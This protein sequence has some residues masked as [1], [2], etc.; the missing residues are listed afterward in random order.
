MRLA[1][2]AYNLRTG[3][4][5]SVGRNLTPALCRAAPQWRFRVIVPQG[6]GYE[7]D[8]GSLPNVELIPC[9][10]S[11][12][13]LGRWV[14]DN[15]TAARLVRE[16]RPDV[17]LGLG[18]RGLSQPP[19][20][21]TIL[22]HDAHLFYPVQHYSSEM[23]RRKVLKAYQR[24][25][26]A[27]HLAVTDLLLCQTLTAEARLRRQFRY[28]GAAAIC[29]NAVPTV[30]EQDGDPPDEPSAL[31]SAKG[32]VRLFC[33][34]RYYAHKN[35]EVLLEC[36]RRYPRELASVIVVA[37]I[38]A[39]HH[40]GAPRFLHDIRQYG[41]ADAIVNVGPVPQA[42]L[43]A[44]YR[45][46]DGLMLP[47][48]L[49]SFSGTYLEAMHFGVPIL[50]SN[51][52]FAREVCGDAAL[53]FD[54]WSPASVKDAMVRFADDAQ[55]RADLASAGR[56]RLAQFGRTWDEIGAELAQRLEELARMPRSS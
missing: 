45:H 34:T 6:Y 7:E 14:F 43:G 53:Y 21:Q 46:C 2:L 5:L 40:P 39:D 1:I 9:A 32:R 37:T 11:Q 42:D 41:L 44:Y 13:V 38:A 47:T 3:G 49:E 51:L 24:W 36:Y 30:L 8:L 55:L 52:D 29:P 17:L 35:L 15:L 10:R 19:C 48:T 50:T 18:N 12:S 22:C 23:L 26:L 27:R 25:V 16:F 28:T 54:P 20:Q 56:T 33:L 4:G 31:A